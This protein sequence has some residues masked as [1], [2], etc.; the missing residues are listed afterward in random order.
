MI[1]IV[2]RVHDL[3]VSA[4][5]ALPRSG[6][7]AALADADETA[8]LVELAALRS[9]VDTA[10][11]AVAA[12]IERKSARELGAAGLARRSGV[13]SGVELVQRLTGVT[14]ADASR[15]VRTGEL[16]EVAEQIAPVP[17][18]SVPLPRSIEALERL[19]GAWDAPIAVAVRN[20]WLTIDQGD[21]LRRGL[22]APREASSSDERAWRAAALRLVVDA[23]EGELTPEDVKRLAA[24]HRAVL[25]RDWAVGN[26]ERLHEQRSLK[27]HVRGDGMVKYDL[28]VDPMTDAQ[29]WAPLFR[30]LAPRLGGPRFMTE[31]ERDRA[32][33]LD[34]DARSNEQLLADAFTGFLIAG[35]TGSGVFGKYVPTVNIAVTL[36]DL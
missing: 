7:I 20:A 26:A 4:E 1:E 24:Q 8:L 35:V 29:L 15:A 17:N 22:G 18:A 13:R 36:A 28:L 25:D 33:E 31:E 30:H 11:A 6:E 14:R 10:M 2:S 23:W 9:R 32:A 21:A 12:D 5:S 16:L 3:A 19:S 34:A 27:R